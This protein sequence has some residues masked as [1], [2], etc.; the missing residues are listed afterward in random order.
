M[1]ISSTVVAKSAQ[2]NSDDLLGGPITIQIT[3][4]KANEGAPDQPVA[5]HYSGDDGKPFLPCKTVR[6]A[7]ISCWGPD[8]AKYV[9]RRM[10]LYRDPEVAFGGM[11]VGGIRVSHMS[12]IEKEA[13]LMLT[14][15]RAKKAPVRIKPL[16]IPQQ[17][18]PPAEP[19]NAMQLAETAARAGTEAFRAWWSS[20]E[21]KSCRVTA[22]A[23]IDRLKELAAEADAA[24]D[25]APM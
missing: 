11:K 6:R 12:D 4:V 2:L 16:Q 24:K 5:V 18:A 10:T 3:A 21:G 9:G 23:N 1:D 7:M 25:E 20:D 19:D 15:T 13:V 8:A 17:S 22:Q 14:T